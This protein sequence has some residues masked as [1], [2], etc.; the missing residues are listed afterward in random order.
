MKKKV[1]FGVIADLH[2]QMAVN[3]EQFLKDFLDECKK[4][5]VDFVIQ[6][7]DFCCMKGP[8]GICDD[9][10]ANDRVLDMYNNFEK[11]S[12]HVVGNHDCDPCYKKETMQMWGMETP[13]YYSFDM[14]GYHFVVLD[15][16]FLRVDGKCVS[17][18]RNEYQNT[19]YLG[20]K[21]EKPFENAKEI[22]KPYLPEEQLEWL[23][24]DL[25]KTKYPSILFSHQRLT[26]EFF[27]KK[28]SEGIYNSDALAK[29]IENAPNGVLLAVNGHEHLDYA[30]KVGKTWF[31]SMNAVTMQWLGED[32]NTQR[33][34]PEQEKGYMLV[35]A[36]LPY[37]DGLYSI[38]TVDEDGAQ[39]KGK[40]AEFVGPGP[41]EMKLYENPK[42]DSFFYEMLPY[43]KITSEI[44]DRYMPF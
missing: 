34:S 42:L 41:S 7:G 25:E 5:N 36:T 33:Y 16:N 2:V 31:Y 12:Y 43:A 4:E 13:S 27:G 37:T 10:S 40:K 39:V 19:V 35:Q 11:P 23:K 44:E 18:D 8:I 6:L 17:Y 30:Q 20:D 1:K 32:F 3:A 9:Y 21:A 24:N 38:I 29:I 14:N 22:I 26:S 28:N 15:P